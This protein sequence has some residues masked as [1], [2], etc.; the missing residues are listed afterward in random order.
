MCCTDID[1]IFL[2]FLSS[3][4]TICIYN[5]LLG[6]KEFVYT[7]SMRTVLSFQFD[8]NKSILNVGFSHVNFMRN[9]HFCDWQWHVVVQ[10][11]DPTIKSTQVQNLSS[12]TQYYVTLSK[13]YKYAA[14]LLPYLWNCDNG[15]S[16][17]GITWSN[18]YKELGKK[19]WHLVSC[20]CN[21]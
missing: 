17:K 1:K 13:L 4:S 15:I 10:S 2:A 8:L 12:S 6:T 11:T 20:K 5:T 14:P 19:P 21:Y 7:V 18:R 3:Y 9:N 16:F